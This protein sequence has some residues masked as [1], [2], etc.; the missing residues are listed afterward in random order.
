MGGIADD[1]LVEVAD[2]D[3]DP[4]LGVGQRAEIAKVA[5]PA[6]PHRRTLG[7]LALAR[8]QPLVELDRAAAH[9]GM[10]RPRHLQV[11]RQCQLRRSLFRARQIRR[12]R[13][14]DA[15]SGTSPQRF[16][17]ASSTGAPSSS[18]CPVNVRVSGDGRP[19]AS[20]CAFSSSLR[21]VIRS[22]SS[23]MSS[24]AARA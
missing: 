16:P 6:D 10:R 7:D 17:A 5:V 2:L 19:S 21:A 12:T 3:R 15:C 23:S 4:A 1:G 20:N 18:S 24:P 11:A 22:P 14:G 13:L 9:I 8:L